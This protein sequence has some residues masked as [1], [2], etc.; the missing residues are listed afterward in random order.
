M[1]KILECKYET[2]TPD[3]RI[4]VNAGGYGPQLESQLLDHRDGGHL[5]QAG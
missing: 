4:Q 2:R 1:G 3:T 5:E